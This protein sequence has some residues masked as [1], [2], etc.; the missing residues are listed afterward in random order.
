MK[1]W[2]SILLLLVV[3]LAGLAVGIVGTRI[4]VRRAVQ[5]AIAHPERVQ[6]LVER[7]LVRKLQL[8]PDQQAKLQEILTGAR[9]HLRA[10]RQEY[11]PQSLA[12]LRAADGQIMALLSPEQMARYENFKQANRP[13]WSALQN[14]P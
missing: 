5:Q 10:L 14:R 2:K 12:V 8:A 7:D 13:F 9:D 11:Q 6:H 4:I 3:F 1:K